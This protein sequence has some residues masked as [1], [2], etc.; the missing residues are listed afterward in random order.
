MRL[1]N[2]FPTTYNRPAFP[3]NF[4]EKA[5][6]DLLNDFPATAKNSWAQTPAVNIV[7]SPENFRLEVAAPG[8]AKENFEVKVENELLTISA[9]KEVSKEENGKYTRREFGYFGFKRSFVL[10]DTVNADEIAATYEN[11]ILN[12]TLAKK[13]EAKPAPVRTIEIA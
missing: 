9:Q 2:V 12:V 7:E 11:G 4:I 5:F 6:N 3:A 8:L 1:I 13:A 10:P